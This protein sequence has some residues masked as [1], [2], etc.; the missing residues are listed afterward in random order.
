MEY[1]RPVLNLIINKINANSESL[2]DLRTEMAELTS[3]QQTALLYRGDDEGGVGGVKILQDKVGDLV[4]NVQALE[5]FNTTKVEV[6]DTVVDA[7]TVIGLQV[8]EILQRIEKLEDAPPSSAPLSARSPGILLSTMLIDGEGAE[9]TSLG[10]LMFKCITLENEIEVMRA[11]IL[12]QGG[13]AFGT[14]R[15]ASKD[16]LLRLIMKLHKK[17]SG[18]AAF[19]DA[20]SL[21]CHDKKLNTSTNSHRMLSRLG[22]SNNVARNYMISFGQ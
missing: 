3:S 22:V 18:L 15:F 6:A 1:V 13:K 11:E 7:A 12:A 16:A 2:G 19:S 14:H 4:S 5:D 9:V 10:D 17:G 8:A 20:S 21:F